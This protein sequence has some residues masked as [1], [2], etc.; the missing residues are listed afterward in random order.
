MVVWS[1]LS[2]GSSPAEWRT[3]SVAATLSGPVKR[4][5]PQAECMRME[6]WG[7]KACLAHRQTRGVGWGFWGVRNA[8]AI[9]AVR[10]MRPAR[11][12]RIATHPRVPPEVHAAVHRRHGRRHHHRAVVY[13]PP[14]PKSPSTS[15]RRMMRRE[16]RA[17]RGQ[18]PAE[19]GGLLHRHALPQ[20]W[21]PIIGQG[22]KCPP[23]PLVRRLHAALG[24]E[25]LSAYTASG[26]LRPRP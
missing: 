9:D 11:A 20:K 1:N 10:R 23:P 25:P 8:G 24:H 6:R 16:R 19:T 3:V 2:D 14:S 17:H 4:G 7:A 5:F 22:D 12:E 18:T 15:H 13:R 26:V 21:T